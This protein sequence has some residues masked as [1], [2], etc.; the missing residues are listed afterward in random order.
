MDHIE[1]P[2]RGYPRL[3][4]RGPNVKWRL[5]LDQKKRDS[6]RER[7]RK[8]VTCVYKNFERKVDVLAYTYTW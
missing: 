1:I 7:E 4:W 5:C 2:R 6:E 8:Y 3:Q